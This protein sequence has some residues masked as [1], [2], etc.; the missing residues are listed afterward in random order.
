MQCATVRL[1]VLRSRLRAQYHP[2]APRRPRPNCPLWIRCISS[3]LATEQLWRARHG[4]NLQRS[5]TARLYSSAI[6]R[7]RQALRGMIRVAHPRFYRDARDAS[8]ITRRQPLAGPRTL[9]LPVG[10]GAAVIFYTRPL[11]C[12]GCWPC[13]R[14]GTWWS[15]HIPPITYRLSAHLARLAGQLNSGRSR[16]R[17]FCHASRRLRRSARRAAGGYSLLSPN[18]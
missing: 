16:N 18:S 2:R 3:M 6:D 1:R 15:A 8:G 14:S 13:W 11:A 17:R 5:S 10:R 12:S 9:R 4:P 7:R